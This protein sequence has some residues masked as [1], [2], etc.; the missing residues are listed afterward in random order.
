[1]ERWSLADLDLSVATTVDVG[2]I[3]LVLG[4]AQRWLTA[5]G[6]EQWTL[7]FDEGWVREKI[8][9]GEFWLADIGGSPV[10]VVR[11]LWE[12]PLFW[13]TRDQGDAAYIHTLAVHRKFAGRGIGS[14]ILRWAEEQ[15]RGRGRRFLRLDCESDNARLRQYYRRQGFASLGESRVG[16]ATVTL[17]EKQIGG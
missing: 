3:L 7:P 4:D 6:I 12:D 16:P 1:V 13:G 9:A 2:S 10:A 15:A 8:A 14:E 11:L 5:Q 17:L